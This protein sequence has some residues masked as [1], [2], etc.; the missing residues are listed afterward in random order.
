MPKPDPT[1]FAPPVR[2]HPTLTTCAVTGGDLAALGAAWLAT[3]EFAG[4]RPAFSLV[5]LLGVVH[6]LAFSAGGL[7]AQ[8]RSV[9]GLGLLRRVVSAWLRSVAVLAVVALLLPAWVERTAGLWLCGLFLAGLLVIRFGTMQLRHFVRR[10][11]ANQRFVVIAGTGRTAADIAE[12]IAANPAWGMQVIGFLAPSEAPARVVIAPDRVV[13]TYADLPRLARGMVIDEIVV[14]DHR[15]SMA[16]VAEVIDVGRTLGLRTHVVADFLP[17]AWRSVEA[18]SLREHVLLSLTPFPNDVFGLSVKRAIDVAV[19]LAALALLLPLLPLVALGIKLETPGPV[20][21]VHPRGGLNGRLFRLVKLR[22]MCR[23]AEARLDALRDQNEM[24]GPVFKLR[25]DP[26][27]TRVGRLLRRFSIDELPQLWN[28][29]LGQM[30]LVGPRPLMPHEVDGHETWQRRRMSMR[31][32]L[33][34]LWQVSGRNRIDYERW[35]QLD[36]EYIDNWSLAMD[37]RILARTMPVVL[38][39]HGAA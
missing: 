30:S 4:V 5:V 1:P 20:F 3:A 21:F 22:T 19:S 17:G 16:A 15:S 36:L 25:A 28:V 23:D 29:L 6:S 8:L 7:H 13:G 9:G 38:S 32:G 33:T 18:R 35:M 27:V 2:S 31:P 14:A 37:L 10:R 34:C 39:G 24:S 26:R 11:G 12:A